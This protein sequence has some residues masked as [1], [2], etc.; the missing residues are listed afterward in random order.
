MKQFRSALADRNIEFNRNLSFVG[1]KS[2]G[3]FV[4]IKYKDDDTE[5]TEETETETEKIEIEKLEKIIKNRD[6]EILKLKKQIEELK[7]LNVD[8]NKKPCSR[9]YYHYQFIP[10]HHR[11]TYYHIR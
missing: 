11:F 8:N 2:R 6:S 1:I 5:E 10:S 9:I 7:R 4:G 3:G